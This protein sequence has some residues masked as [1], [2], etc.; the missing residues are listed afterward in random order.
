MIRGLALRRA[1]DQA[2]SLHSLIGARQS[3]ANYRR[4]L[5][6][7]GADPGIALQLDMQ[8]LEIDNLHRSLASDSLA[9]AQMSTRCD[10]RYSVK[11]IVTAVQSC[12]LLS[13]LRLI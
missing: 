1:S 4:H 3:L 11:M 10:R 6:Q 12:T 13:G 9:F 7:D 2:S 5:Q 8:I